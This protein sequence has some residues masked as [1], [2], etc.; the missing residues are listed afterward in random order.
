MSRLL[1]LLCLCL[2]FGTAAPAQTVYETEPDVTAD[3]VRTRL[4]ARAAFLYDATTGQALYERNIDEPL[5]PA[6]TTKLITAILVME[7]RGLTGSLTVDP[8]DTWV[9][10]SHVP[11]VPGETVRVSELMHSLLIASDN[12]SAL[13]L[14][15]YTAGS[16]PAFVDLMNQRAV[17]LGCLHTHFVNPNGLPARGLETTARDLLKIFQKAL[18]FPVLE[19]IMQTKTYWLT[20]AHGTQLLKNHN[21]LLGKYPGMGPAKTGWTVA[22]RHTYAAASTRDGHRLELIILNSPDKWKDAT[23]LFNY[24]FSHLPPLPAPPVLKPAT[25]ATMAPA[26]ASIR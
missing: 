22:S 14:A 18:T 4:Q 12:D 1:S 9:E 24:G 17:E 10:P 23:L 6:S 20:T 16:V 3:M 8:E 26:Q 13:A 2:C 7:R 11:L 15:R 19:Q 5:P 21:K 25:P